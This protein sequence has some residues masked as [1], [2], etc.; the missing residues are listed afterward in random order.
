[1]LQSRGLKAERSENT[2]QVVGYEAS[3]KSGS[4][5]RLMHWYVIVLPP[6]S[7]L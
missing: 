3:S 4:H 7:L 1:M 6:L 2:G 5:G